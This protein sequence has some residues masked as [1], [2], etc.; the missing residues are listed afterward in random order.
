MPVRCSGRGTE[1]AVGDM[2]FGVRGGVQVRDARVRVIRGG[3]GTQEGRA[4]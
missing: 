4:L 2:N 3:I 1:Q